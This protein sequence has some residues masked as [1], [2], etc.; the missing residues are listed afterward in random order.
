M[1]LTTDMIAD[2][3]TINWPESVDD[4][5]E[6]WHWGRHVSLGATG[7]GY[8]LISDDEDAVIIAIQRPDLYDA[9]GNDEL[10]AAIRAYHDEQLRIRDEA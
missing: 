4:A 10:H 1:S 6:G 3:A 8:Y 2:D 9:P 5:P 7:T